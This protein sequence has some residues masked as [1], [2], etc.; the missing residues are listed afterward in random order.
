MR[1]KLESIDFILADAILNGKWYSVNTCDIYDID[2]FPLYSK[3]PSPEKLLIK[4]QAYEQLSQEAKEIIEEII[5]AP[6]ELWEMLVTPGRKI[7]SKR[8]IRLFFQQVFQ[9]KFIT[10]NAFEEISQ[11]VDQL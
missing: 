8:S 3:I 2:E 6:N 1:K 9:S 10:E 11:W 4:K 5:Y 7:L